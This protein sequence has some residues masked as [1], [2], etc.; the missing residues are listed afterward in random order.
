MSCVETYIYTL[1]DPDTGV[2]RYVGKSVNPSRR[3]IRHLSE[4]KTAAV[5]TYKDN[6]IL[7]LL[8]HNKKPTQQI[9]EVCGNNWVDREKYWISY[10]REVMGDRLTNLTEGGDGLLGYKFSNETKLKMSKAAIGRV[11][12]EE[13]KEKISKTLKGRK[14]P[15]ETREKMAKA[16]QKKVIQIG[17]DGGFI[18][19]WDSIKQVQ[20]TLHID[21][22]QISRCVGGKQGCVTAGGFMWKYFKGNEHLCL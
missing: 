9:I 18:K 1:N 10:Y 7:K 15:K 8:K 21:R 20:K 6:W 14:L 22:S 2:V 13:Q 19:V 4:A 5:K 12:T 17:L 11:I 3:F 16:R